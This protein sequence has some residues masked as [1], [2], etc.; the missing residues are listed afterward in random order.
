MP[1][2]HA[3][4]VTNLDF[5]LPAST[6]CGWRCRGVLYVHSPVHSQSPEG[7]T[8][9]CP[10]PGPFSLVV[11]ISGFLVRMLSNSAPRTQWIRSADDQQWRSLPVHCQ[12]TACCCCCPLLLCCRPLPPTTLRTA[13][14][15]PAGALQSCSMI[16]AC[17]QRL[18]LAATSPTLMLQR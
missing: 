11:F 7:A 6:D 2:M 13:V 18:L 5:S 9:A 3:N 10:Y 4:A 16:S 1:Y 15:S 17:C 14:T 12:L 8:S